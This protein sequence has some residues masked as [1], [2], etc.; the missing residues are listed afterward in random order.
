LNIFKR[1][2]RIETIWK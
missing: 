2:S 1:K